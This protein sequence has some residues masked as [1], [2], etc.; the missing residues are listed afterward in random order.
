MIDETPS[1]TPGYLTVAEAASRLSVSER[2]VRFLIEH[3]DLPASRVGSRSWLIPVEAVELRAA[4][5]AGRGRRLTPNNAWGVLFLSAGLSAE[6]LD[7]KT[8]WRLSSLVRS[9]RLGNLRAQLIDRGR[10]RPYRTHPATL[11]RLRGDPELMHTGTTGASALRLGLVGGGNRMEAYANEPD[12]DALVRRYQ[13]RPSRDPNVTI[14]VIPAL[15]WSWPP[16]H[17]AP[18]SAIALDLLDDPEPRAQQVGAEILERLD[19]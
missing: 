13:L 17:V 12:L 5:R 6:W 10:P 3:G 2:M 11:G 4:H 16:A 15:E 7:R 18:V 19:Q 9:R 1:P 8:R 14:R